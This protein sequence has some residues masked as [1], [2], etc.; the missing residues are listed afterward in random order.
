MAQAQDLGL[1]QDLSAI[2]VTDAMALGVG[3]LY[4]VS[5]WPNNPPLPPL[6]LLA[7]PAIGEDPSG[8]TTNL[9]YSVL[10]SAEW[11]QPGLC[12]LEHE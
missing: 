1:P 12:D 8:S 9:F 11:D 10:Q 7:D 6:V 3:R 4:R 2:S 5:T